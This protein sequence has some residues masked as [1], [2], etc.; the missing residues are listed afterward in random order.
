MGYAKFRDTLKQGGV[1][2]DEVEAKRIVYLYRNKY[3]AIKKL[4]TRCDAVIKDMIGGRSGN[5]SDM[6]DYDAEGIVLP[7]GMKIKYNGLLAKEQGFVYVSGVSRTGVPTVANIYGGKVVENIVQALARIVITEQMVAIGQQYHVVFQVH[8][9]I[10]IYSPEATATIAQQDIERV[11]S[12]PPSWVE[13][14]PI[15]CESD[16]GN[17]YGE[18]K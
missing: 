17:N 7:N 4:W 11:M 14:L 3:P 5:I 6:L 15:A 13:D 12:T 18:C 16:I 2:I 9:E 8:D 1:E 10:I